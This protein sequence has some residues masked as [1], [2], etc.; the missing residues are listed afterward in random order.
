VSILSGIL[1]LTPAWPIT[2][3]LWLLPFAW[4]VLNVVWSIM[5]GVKV[6]AGGSYRYPFSLRLIK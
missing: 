5:G 1:F 4:W 3:I 2:G 6:N